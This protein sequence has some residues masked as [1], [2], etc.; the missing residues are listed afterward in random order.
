MMYCAFHVVKRPE[1]TAAAGGYKRQIVKGGSR[2]SLVKASEVPVKQESKT[3]I[4]VIYE[5]R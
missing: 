4:E 2:G 1:A 5:N 3:L